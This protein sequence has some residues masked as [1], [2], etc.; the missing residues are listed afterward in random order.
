[1]TKAAAVRNNVLLCPGERLP[2]EWCPSP[3]CRLALRI[4]LTAYNF[5]GK[6]PRVHTVITVDISQAYRNLEFYRPG[7]RA[8]I[9]NGY[10]FCVHISVLQNPMQSQTQF[11]AP[12]KP[13]R[14]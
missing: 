1:M 4:H 2:T 13:A 12:G 10:E 11:A 7:L 6:A 3:F 9:G 14:R 8:S 5:A